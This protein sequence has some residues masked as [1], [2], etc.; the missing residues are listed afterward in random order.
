VLYLCAFDH[1]LVA[2]VVEENNWKAMHLPMAECYSGFGDPSYD[3]YL[4]QGQLYFAHK[5]ASQLSIWFLEDPSS[6]N[7]TFK[8]IVSHLQ[9]LET[10]YLAYSAGYVVLSIHPEHNLIFLVCR[11]KETLM[12]YDMDSREVH[13]L[14]QLGRDGKIHRSK[15]NYLPYVPLYSELLADGH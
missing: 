5:G 13:I 15:T 11:Y 1:R 4:S 6:E 8:H 10:Q 9:M 14:C 3:I 7:W 2:L 12:S